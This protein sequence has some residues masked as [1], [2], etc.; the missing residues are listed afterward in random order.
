MTNARRALLA[1]R[2]CESSG[3]APDAP[4]TAAGYAQAER[5]ADALGS[6]GIARIVSSPYRRAR[7]TA[8]PLAQRLGIEIEV[9]ERL[10]ERRLSPA[11]LALA[12]WR[13]HVERSFRE[14]D[15]RAPGGESGREAV[16]R[17]WAALHDALRVDRTLIASH[18]QLLSLV[19]HRIDARFGFAGWSA[20]T[21]PDVFR[22]ERD[23][24]GALRFDR[25]WD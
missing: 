6:Q 17:G 10:A 2:H 8:L 1:V 25:A 4:L 18:G 20:M 9:D 3:Q 7:E 22:I 16:T 11:P 23:G 15:A 12:D 24:E 21:N 5:L 13:A 14:P 19:L